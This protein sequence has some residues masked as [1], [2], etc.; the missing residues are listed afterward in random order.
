M[1]GN[2]N[3]RTEFRFK[4]DFAPPK[5]TMRMLENENGNRTARTVVPF[6][7]D[8][9]E[10]VTVPAGGGGGGDIRVGFF[11]HDA[12]AADIAAAATTVW[13]GVTLADGIA[14]SSAAAAAATSGIAIAR[15]SPSTFGVNVTVPTATAGKLTRVAF[16]IR[17]GAASDLAGHLSE[18]ARFQSVTHDSK[19]PVIT[20]VT[21]DDWRVTNANPVPFT[22]EVD[23]PVLGLSSA[24][25]EVYGGA[26]VP[27][28]FKV[29]AGGSSPTPALMASGGSSGGTAVHGGGGCGG[30]GGRGGDVGAQVHL[31]RRAT[32]LV[33]ARGVDG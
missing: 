5:P 14:A 20:F 27:G 1:T 9:G 4:Y 24:D 31:Q 2:R 26:L 18:E 29:A 15:I 30:D 23:E 3:A 25:V 16:H 11:P 7:L 19:P 17:P 21:E 22:F 33:E 6:V 10:A 8:F 28:S 32:A 12:T 13:S